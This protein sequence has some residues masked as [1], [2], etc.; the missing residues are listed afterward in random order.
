MIQLP[1]AA[2]FSRL[3][4]FDLWEAQCMLAI[5]PSESQSTMPRPDTLKIIGSK[6]SIIAVWFNMLCASQP[7]HA[8]NYTIDVKNLDVHMGIRHLCCQIQR[9][10]QIFSN[11]QQVCF[12]KCLLIFM[13]K[14]IF[15]INF[16]DTIISSIACQLFKNN[17]MLS[18]QL[19]GHIFQR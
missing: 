13:A 15:Y 14:I 18:C 8:H 1:H 2:V 3:R 6:L 10:Q 4:P 19:M 16:H 9:I 7:P 17:A 5:R 12:I 11:L